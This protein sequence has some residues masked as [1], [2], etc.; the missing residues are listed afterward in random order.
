MLGA[1]LAGGQ[2]FLLQDNLKRTYEW[3]HSKWKVNPCCVACTMAGEAHQERCACQARCPTGQEHPVSALDLCWL[4][5]STRESARAPQLPQPQDHDTE[6]R[7]R[8][9]QPQDSQTGCWPW[10]VTSASLS[11]ISQST[12][13]LVV[14]EEAPTPPPPQLLSKNSPQSQHQNTQSSS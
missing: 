8:H 12:S 14:L 1:G 13:A 9:P 7:P 2:K 6:P 4:L 10:S 11:V 5:C 3:A